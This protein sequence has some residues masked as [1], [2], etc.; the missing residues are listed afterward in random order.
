[1]DIKRILRSYDFES[2]P[3]FRSHEENFTALEN[4]Q[5]MWKKLESCR[6]E[7]KLITIHNKID[8]A[9]SSTSDHYRKTVISSIL[10]RFPSLLAKNSKIEENFQKISTE[11]SPNKALKN[12]SHFCVV[13]GCVLHSGNFP[14]RMRFDENVRCS[15]DNN[16]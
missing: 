3:L 4:L 12:R 10:E 16:N 8:H 9:S 6:I 13:R 14:K 11:P 1:M 2:M 7:S 5:N 15:F